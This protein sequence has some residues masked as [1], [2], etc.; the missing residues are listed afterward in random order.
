MHARD[1][2]EEHR[3]VSQVEPRTDLLTRLVEECDVNAVR[4]QRL[5]RK[6]SS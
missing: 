5:T 6:I 4:K 1:Y 2:P 3:T